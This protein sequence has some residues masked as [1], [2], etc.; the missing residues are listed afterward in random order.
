VTVTEPFSAFALA[1][2]QLEYTRNEYDEHA[3]AYAE[4]AL[5]AVAGAAR[6]AGVAGDTVHAERGQVYGTLSPYPALVIVTIPH[7]RAAGIDPNASGCAARSKRYSRLRGEEDDGKPEQHR[8]ER[9]AGVADRPP[10]DRQDQARSG[11]V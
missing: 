9:L 10:S 3:K 1:P 7:H 8:E 6:L 4:Q 2:N 11:Q 5:A